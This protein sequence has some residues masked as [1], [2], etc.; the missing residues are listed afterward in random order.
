MEKIDNPTL[1]FVVNHHPFIPGDKLVFRILE[2]ETIDILVKVDNGASSI[3][4]EVYNSVNKWYYPVSV[5]PEFQ[6]SI[7]DELNAMENAITVKLCDKYQL[8]YEQFIRS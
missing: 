3:Y 8:A 6:G 5:M 2:D 1:D 4:I 7:V